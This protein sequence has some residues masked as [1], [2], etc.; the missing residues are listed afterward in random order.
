[1]YLPMSTYG[2]LWYSLVYDAAVEQLNVTL[3]K[4]KDLPGESL[5]MEWHVTF[6]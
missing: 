3:I 5:C 4:V 2:R 1:M 6:S